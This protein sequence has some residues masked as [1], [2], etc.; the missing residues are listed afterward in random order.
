[1]PGHISTARRSRSMVTA[2]T[3][4]AGVALVVLLFA[5]GGNRASSAPAAPPPTSRSSSVSS[6]ADDAASRVPVTIFIMSRC[7]DAQYCESFLAPVL[8]PLKQH[9]RLRAEYIVREEEKDAGGGG[10]G[11]KTTLAC[12]HGPQE[13]AG[14]KA[15]LC[16]QDRLDSRIAKGL[17]PADATVNVFL[18]FLTCG[19]EQPA[20]IG[21]DAG[22]RRCLAKAGYA[23][24]DQADVVKCSAGEEGEALLAASHKATL[25]AGAT[26]SC[27]IH[28]AGKLRC[29]RDGGAF[30]DCEG[31]SRP[32]DF[33]A[34]ICGALGGEARARAEA[35]GAC[36]K[37]KE[38]DG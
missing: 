31:G 33:A 24:Q 28:V 10:G 22:T 8:E 3:A 2:A 16:L 7:P 4:L 6:A 1:M 27:T 17:A 12:M 9:V 32:E 19:W 5:G 38:Q 34:T 29:V 30:K 14:N 35:A 20:T 18:R 25:A 26:K 36:A 21:T 23:E 37:K 13:C 15:Q 11:K